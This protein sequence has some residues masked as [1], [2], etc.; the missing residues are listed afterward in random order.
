MKIFYLPDLGE[1]LPD[2]EIREWLIQEGDEVKVDQPIVSM[3]TAKALVDVPSPYKGKISKLYGNAGDIIKTGNPLVGYDEGDSPKTDA[4]TVVGSIEVG[5]KVISESPTGIQPRNT[6][7][8]IRVTPA[9]RSLAKQ[10]NV[11][12]EKITPTG[13]GGTIS[14]Q[15]VKAAGENSPSLAEGFEPL[16]GARRSMATIMALAHSTVVPVTLSDDANIHHFDK[17]E[18]ITL[19]LIRAIVHAS[20]TEPALNAHFD[21]KN[22][23]HKLFAEVNIGLAVDTPQ[24]LYV[25]VIKKAESQSREQL[26][27]TINSFK[28]HAKEQNFPKE[29]LQ[30]ATITLSNFGVFVGRYANPIVVP[31]T[32]AIIGIGKLRDEVVAI[33]GRAEIQ[34]IM[35]ISLTFDHRAATGGEAA[36]FLAAL[37]EDLQS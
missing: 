19:R 10:L 23:S 28:Q 26:R 22:I 14:V 3:E 36:R 13:P 4:G 2:A 8:S 18:D 29:S 37:I 25:P 1:G 9:V 34:R 33:E 12:L 5:S 27:A 6:S 15:D 30:G 17:T 16:H 32:V 21:G 24:G 7:Q 11:D 35:P 20:K 31:P